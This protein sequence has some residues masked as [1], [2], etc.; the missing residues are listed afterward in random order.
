MAAASPAAQELPVAAVLAA[1]MVAAMA[2]GV[3]R[4]NGL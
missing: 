2:G 3:L 4:S 1:A